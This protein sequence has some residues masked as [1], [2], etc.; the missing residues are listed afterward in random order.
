MQWNGSRRRVLGGVLLWSAAVALV[1][2]QRRDVFVQPRDIA[3]I[4]YSTGRTDNAATR[5]NQRLQD[6][7]ARLSFNPEN[8]YLRSML[9]VLG[10]STTSQMLVF[11]QTSQQ[12]SLIG[13][14]NPRALY[15]GDAVAVGWVRG[16][17]RLEV[18]VQD[19]RQG[20]VFYTLDQKEGAAP[21]LVRNN[22]CLACHLTWETLGVPGFMATSMYPLPDDPNAYAN[23][24]TTIHGS[25]LEQRWG[26]WWVT[27]DHGGARHMGNVPVMPVDKGRARPNPRGVLK[28]V[29]GIFDLRGF[30]A[31]TSD[32]VA[33]L[34]L[35][36]QTQMMNHL[37]RVAWEARVAAA[38]PSRDAESRVIEAAADVAAY[39]LF[40]DEAPLTGPVKGASGYAEWFSS[41]GPR[42]PQGRSLR[43]FDLTRRLFKYPCSYLIYSEAFDALPPTAKRAVYARLYDVLSGKVPAVRGQR[44]PAPAERRAIIDILRATKSDL[45]EN[46]R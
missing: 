3:A 29:E 33:L 26:G 4:Q 44:V 20:G 9:D 31:P 14:H 25:P 38:T 43:E 12:A 19:P 2:A 18:A 28:S 22:D 42:D 13:I 7:T 27:G 40:L 15:L 8:G 16:A 35:N 32:V 24:F 34:V 41:Q 36:H 23:G 21:R 30:P 39:M 46:F 11:S 10:L 17:D 6:G 37:T 1:T 5:L 45:P